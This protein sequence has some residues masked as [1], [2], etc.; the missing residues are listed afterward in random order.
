MYAQMGQGQR[1]QAGQLP[2]R[3]RDMDQ[4]MSVCK[5]SREM[6]QICTV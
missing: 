5:Q 4:V 2:P 3:V 1:Q 6:E